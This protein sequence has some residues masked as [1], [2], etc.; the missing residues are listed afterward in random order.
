MH[1]EKS[2]QERVVI[3]LNL[4]FGGDVARDKQERT[5]RFL[6]EALELSQSLGCTEEEATQLVKYV[7]SRNTGDTFIEAGGTI[8]TLA[9]LCNAS[10]IDMENAGEEE[11]RRVYSKIDI[12][13][14]KRSAR[15]EGSP[16][17]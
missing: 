7:F 10:D 6:E 1:N 2:F 17:P 8:L 3:W 5:Y 14:R 9:A 13:R 11:L 12:I 15:T 16:L 4:C